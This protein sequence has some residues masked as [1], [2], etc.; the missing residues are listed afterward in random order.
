MNRQEFMKTLEQLL[1]DISP[2]ERQNAIEFYNDYFDD[3]GEENEA[4]VIRELESPQRVA[5]KI[6][7]GLFHNDS[8]SGDYTETGYSDEM[9]PKNM[10]VMAGHSQPKKTHDWSKI[11]LIGMILILCCPVLG[12]MFGVVAGVLGAFVGILGAIFGVVLAMFA[13]SV[14]MW[15]GG[16]ALV[17]AAFAVSCLPGEALLIAGA[18]C[19]MIAVGFGLFVLAVWSCKIFPL[20]IRGCVKLFKKIF[21]KKNVSKA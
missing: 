21:Q 19:L 17:V 15:I 1:S 9:D 14:A 3:A 6:K 18:G 12:A 16:L 20:L 13:V 5:A 11:L 8:S 7:E 10:Q 2:A 4:M